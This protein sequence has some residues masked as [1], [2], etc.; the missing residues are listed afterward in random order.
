MPFSYR[1]SELK[2]TRVVT[3][4]PYPFPLRENAWLVRVVVSTQYEKVTSF[5]VR[6]D[7]IEP[8]ETEDRVWYAATDENGSVKWAYAAENAIIENKEDADR[9][10]NFVREERDVIR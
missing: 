7:T 3:V 10:A 9:I 6:K 5:V 4:I 1:G 2:K 8:G